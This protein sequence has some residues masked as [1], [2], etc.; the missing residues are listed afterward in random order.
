MTSP[1]FHLSRPLAVRGRKPQG[2]LSVWCRS[3][4]CPKNRV[5][6]ETLLGSLGAGIAECQDIRKAD[7]VFIN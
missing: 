7:L 5:D 6:T 4:G 3:L 2:F 1:D